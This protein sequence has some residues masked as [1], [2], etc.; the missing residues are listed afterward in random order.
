MKILLQREQLER[1]YRDIL[2]EA[3]GKSF[4]FH[5]HD[6][7]VGGVNPKM[8]F[9]MQNPGVSE[10]EKN[11]DK[12]NIAEF[13][14]HHD[15]KFTEWVMNDHKEAIEKIFNI[16]AKYSLIRYGGRLEGYLS[17]N[18]F[19]DFYL[20]DIVKCRL[21]T[22]ENK[23]AIAEQYLPF[24]KREVSIAN[25][26]IVV[27]FSARSWNVLREDEDFMIPQEKKDLPITQVHGDV[28]ESGYKESRFLLIPVIHFTN[29]GFKNC[30]KTS[31]IDY[32]E[33]SFKDKKDLLEKY[34]AK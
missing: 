4:T 17:N 3:K 25:P 29:Q 6:Y 10:K 12:N 22:K 34:I 30:P 24:F 20:T 7:L 28:I 14:K 5:N 19:K 1:L 32:L 33:R 26:R 16:F 2:N 18:F 8:M 15:G 31:Y 21:T 23:K 27:L 9:V 13:T 11:L